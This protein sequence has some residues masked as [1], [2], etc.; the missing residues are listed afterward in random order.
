MQES[1]ATGTE[2]I[3]PDRDLRTLPEEHSHTKTSKL[4]LD[5]YRPPVPEFTSSPLKLSLNTALSLQAR[6]IRVLVLPHCHTLTQSD[7]RVQF[8]R[9]DASFVDGD[10]KNVDSCLIGIYRA[11]VHQPDALYSS[12]RWPSSLNNAARFIVPGI[13]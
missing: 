3:I 13:V 12:C 10:Q 8:D 4:Q 1:I 9:G 2:D 5:G 11:R 7:S 6:L